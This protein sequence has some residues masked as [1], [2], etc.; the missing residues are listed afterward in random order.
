MRPAQLVA[1]SAI[2]AATVLPRLV[3]AQEGRPT[4]AGLLLGPS[5]YELSGRGT[6][7]A[8]NLDFAIPV[9]RQ[10]LLL[11]P[12]FGFFSHTTQFGN[13]SQWLFP[14]I[15]LQAQGHLGGIRPYVG[16]G[17]GAGSQS[18]GDPNKW[19]ATLHGVAGLRVHLSGRWGT[20]VELRLR[21]V[22]PWES[23]TADFGI[24]LTHAS[25]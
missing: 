3:A 19:V 13:K 10:T 9:F 24:G 1:L 17:I 8:F 5:T 11:E 20:R 2:L 23:H 21:A 16:G 25:F 6:G 15:G 14:E 7:F 18:L 4:E 22:S 12:G